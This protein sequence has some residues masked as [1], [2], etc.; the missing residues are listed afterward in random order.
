[1]LRRR[2]R[3]ACGR[4][5]CG[6]SVWACDLAMRRLPV[7]RV[8]RTGGRHGQRIRRQ[9]CIHRD[10]ASARRRGEGCRGHHCALCPR[11]AQGTGTGAADGEPV[12]HRPRQVPVLR[13][14]QGRRGVRGAP[15]DAALQDDD[16]GR[17]TAPA[18]PAR[19]GAV[20]AG[21]TEQ[22]G[23]TSLP[24]GSPPPPSGTGLLG[25]GS[26]FFLAAKR[27]RG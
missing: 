18:E 4:F 1:M 21:Y 24:E 16:P 20:R 10:V 3:V 27:P 6:R 5:G 11:G 13:G 26:C 17:R 12:R 15:A 8:Q 23:C 7:R 9:A 14:V 19:A 2:G 22:V 25:G